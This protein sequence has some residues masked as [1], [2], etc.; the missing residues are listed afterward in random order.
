MM[1][2]MNPVRSRRMNVGGLGMKNGIHD[3]SSI[4]LIES[5]S[6]FRSG[7]CEKKA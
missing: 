6:A 2:Y 1:S 4:L 5:I 3:E 7:I